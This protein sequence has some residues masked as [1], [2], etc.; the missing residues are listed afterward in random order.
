VRHL[1]EH[2]RW[3]DEGA[4]IGAQ[5]RGARHVVIIGNVEIRVER[6]GV[7]EGPGRPN[8]SASSSSIRLAVSL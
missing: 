6:A 8:S 2:E 1:G 7:Y 3:N 5:E 4:R